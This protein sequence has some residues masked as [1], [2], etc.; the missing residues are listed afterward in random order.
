[1]SPRRV[2]ILL[3]FIV[4]ATALGGCA[5]SRSAG[6]PAAA[7]SAAGVITR[8]DLAATIRFLA[9]DALEGRGPGTRADS[10]TRL[11][12]A[13]RMEAL[14]LR[15]GGTG[16][17][18]E[19]PIELIGI[20]TSTPR[21]WRFAAGAKGVELERG[22]EFVA[23]S[24]RVAQRAS[25]ENAEVVFVGYGIQAPEYEWDDIGG[26]DLRDKVLL[27]LNDDPDWDP[28]LFGGKRRLYY[29]RWTYKYE[30]AARHGAVG[31]IVVHTDASA[32]YP[33]QTVQTSWGGEN[34]RLPGA[35]EGE[36]EVRAWIT[37]EATRRLVALAGR[38]WSDLVEA[39]KS[40]DFS[41]VPL[42]VTTSFEVRN[43]L[44]PYETANV[45]G[46]L[47][48]S[49]PALREQAVVYSAHHDHLGIAAA[50]HGADAIYNGALDNATGVAQMLAIA[51]A[52]SALPEAPRRSVLFAAVAAEEQGLLGSRYFA[53][54]PPI[55]RARLAANLNL[56]GGSIWG[57]TRNIAGVGFGKSTL[58]DFVRAAAARQGRS[59]V[60]EQFPEQ[61]SF[62]RSDQF[63][64]AKIGVPALMLRAGTDIVGQ[65]PEWGREQVQAWIA[66]HYHQ[67]SDEF[68][69]SWEFDGMIE[70][71]RLL[72]DVGLAVAEADE[73]PRWVP[74]DEFEA[75]RL[76]GETTER[77]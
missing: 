9:D 3:S 15:P 75:V 73:M 20:T 32:G 34:S 56:D 37:E 65:P 43:T 77:R 45:V 58:D 49:D 14:G 71:A 23:A 63:N 12:L 11:Y 61:G 64:F 52:F 28:D 41:P 67:P 2:S 17:G 42:G 62:Y 72:F 50:D 36:L 21:Q 60:D 33:W 48:G 30:I 55:P 22:A 18:W 29:G 25:I 47:P 68:D 10:L 51:R 66:K 54:H 40:R 35:G 76:G 53:A 74:G 16:G 13:T 69:P 46:V 19:Q 26:A 24:P 27:M 31:A 1:M 39:A 57:R 6:A 59:Y 38:D 4:V 44:R 8:D 70:D 7:P 5:A